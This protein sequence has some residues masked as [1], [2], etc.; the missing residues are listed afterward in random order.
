MSSRHVE[1]AGKLEGRGP[2]WT[3]GAV[4]LLMLLGAVLVA[5]THRD[6]GIT[7]D[8]GM[9]SRYGEQA[10]EYFRSGFVAPKT[11]NRGVMRYCG[12]LV[13]MIPAFFYGEAGSGKYETRHLLLG[14]LALLFI[15]GLY[16]YGRQFEDWRLPLLA[17]GALAVMP[18]FYGHIFNNS[19]DIPF[20]VAMIWFMAA[21]AAMFVR[22]SRSW[23]RVVVC[24]LAMG[25]VLMVRPGGFTILAVFFLAAAGL[26]DLTRGGALSGKP[27]R[28]AIWLA[29]A[30][31]ALIV[32]I[33][34]FL[35]VVPWPW[36]HQSPIAHPLQAMKQA[37]QFPVPVTMLFEGR[38]VESF[39]LPRWYLPEYLLITAPPTL[40]FLCGIGG[41]CVLWRQVTA[42][43]SRRSFLYGV[44]ELWLLAPVAAFVVLRPHVYDGL[45]HFLFLLPAMALLAAIGATC[46]IDFARR[47]WARVLA[48]L[49]VAG[50]LLAPIT[51][52]VRLH[53]YQTTYFNFLV[54][55]V[56]GADGRYETD[57][58]VSSYREAML[59]VNEQVRREPERR[60]R[61]LVGGDGSLKPAASYYAA[62]NVETGFV[63]PDFDRPELPAN[64]D[65]YIA[66]TRFAT[67]DKFPRAP[68]VHTV[69]RGGAVYTVIKGRLPE[70]DDDDASS[71]RSEN[72]GP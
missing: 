29:A 47:P 13:E 16:L 15:P 57:Y 9:Q 50:S 39:D 53:P 56:G 21:V 40:L 65:Y 14:L 51:D 46:L 23:G 6:Y 28:E 49:I 31:L 44:T 7:W 1:K 67:A 17:V 20:A 12:P 70:Q 60:Y 24:G 19:K 27:W 3:L 18:R 4:T 22:R 30:K 62:A 37:M 48:W 5:L 45:R 58:W 2:L 52:L 68:I 36:A 61:V 26:S 32:A 38:T 35:M 66:T 63:G 71:S 11:M 64:A 55:G 41:V 8:E 10:L 72:A 54:G 43:R 25:A 69:G 42:W 33:A 59:W 34:W